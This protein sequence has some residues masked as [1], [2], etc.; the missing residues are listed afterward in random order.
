MSNDKN[1]TELRQ[2]IAERDALF[3]NPTLE[4]AQAWCIKNSFIPPYEKFDVP[5][6]TVHKARLQWLNATN[7]MLA[8]SIAWLE[9]NG[10]EPTFRGAPPLTPKQRDADRIEIGMPP[11]GE[12]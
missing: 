9:A 7:T 12:T 1:I 10:Y 4:S 6:A 3:M 8:E 11:L 2:H 5:L